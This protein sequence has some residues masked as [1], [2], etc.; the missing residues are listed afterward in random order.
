MYALGMA[1]DGAAELALAAEQPVIASTASAQPAAILT[2]RMATRLPPLDCRPEETQHW[3]A[4]LEER[5]VEPA[6]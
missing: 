2:Q 1:I 5:R 3:R 4:E 6:Q